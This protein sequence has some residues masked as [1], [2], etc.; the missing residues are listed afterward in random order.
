MLQNMKEQYKK[1]DVFLE[2]VTKGNSGCHL[3]DISTV[4]F[5]NYLSLVWMKNNFVYLIT[6]SSTLAR[7]NYKNDN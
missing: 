2:W 5:L 1:S 6:Y 4:C 3:V 7:K